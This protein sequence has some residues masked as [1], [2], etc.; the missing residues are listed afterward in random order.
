MPPAQIAR[1]RLAGLLHDVGKT[2][3]PEEILGKPGPLSADEYTLLRYHPELGAHLIDD[4]SLYDIRD[5]VL[6][7]HERPDGN[8]YP[9]GLLGDEVPIES[10]MLAIAD[11]YEAMT[12]DRP[13]RDRLD[14]DDACEE[15]LAC[16]GPQ[17]DPGL[18][19]VFLSVVDS[20]PA[21]R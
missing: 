6:T 4:P 7:H 15:L 14:H 21:G 19:D 18:V 11:A 2:L 8:G 13:Y 1:I 17:F 12:N 16:A 10:R 9:Y 3:L 5:W 20:E